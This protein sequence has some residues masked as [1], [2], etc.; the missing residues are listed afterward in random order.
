MAY[1]AFP[2]TFPEL[3]GEGLVLRELRE[4][5]LPAWL[6]RLSDPEAARLAGDPLATSM[7]TV[8][9]GLACHRAAF[10]ERTG[11][12]WAIVPDGAGA[13][14]G[15]VG[16]LR[17]D[18]G[19]RTAEIGAAIGRAHWGQGIAVR[20]GRLVCGYAFGPLALRAIEAVVL[21]ENARVLRV[22][23]KLGFTRQPGPC[24]EERRVG[25][26]ADSVRFVLAASDEG[27]TAGRR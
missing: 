14:V 9:E 8:R 25:G 21:P 13:S 15:S 27:P 17:L 2:E 12:R 20:A 26:R 6:E 18:A 16:L 1:E 10:R 3:S 24:P 11:I 7:D 22:L 5:D 4:E 19:A 23:A